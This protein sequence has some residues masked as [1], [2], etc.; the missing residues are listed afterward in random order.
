RQHG[1]GHRALRRGP[2][3]GPHRA[4]GLL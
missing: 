4:R 1:G 2:R 3:A